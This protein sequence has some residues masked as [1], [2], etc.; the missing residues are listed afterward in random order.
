MTLNIN[1][2]M[3][4]TK[5]ITIQGGAAVRRPLSTKKGEFIDIE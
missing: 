2:A 5:P 1:T 3:V 4:V